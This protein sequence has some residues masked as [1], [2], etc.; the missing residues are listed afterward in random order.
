MAC[1]VRLI[2]ALGSLGLFYELIF[3]LFPGDLPE[4]SLRVCLYGSNH[5]L[6]EHGWRRS[7]HAS[8]SGCQLRWN[9]CGFF[10][11]DPLGRFLFEPLGL[12]QL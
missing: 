7:P 12:G 1:D 10:K 6:R 4:S 2:C 8:S 9:P 11:M 5:I 3:S